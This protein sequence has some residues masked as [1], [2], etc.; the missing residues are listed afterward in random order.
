MSLTSSHALL[1]LLAGILSVPLG[2]ALYVTV[3]N[4]AGG[5]S[6][7]RVIA[8][9]GW[10]TLVILGLVVMAAAAISIPARFATRAAV[11]DA[12]RYE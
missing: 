11:S 1:A 7:E 3:Y 6:E 2:M 12:L 10:L 4:I 5:S 9:G 8:S